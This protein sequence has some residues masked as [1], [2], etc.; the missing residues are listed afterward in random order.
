MASLSLRVTAQ[1]P[2]SPLMRHVETG[3]CFFNLNCNLALQYTAELLG[4]V[5]F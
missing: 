4:L 3:T 2:S 1:N 5:C